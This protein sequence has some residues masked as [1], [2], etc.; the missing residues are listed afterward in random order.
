MK[1][2]EYKEIVRRISNGALRQRFPGL[3]KIAL[4]DVA[5]T[6]AVNI[7]ARLY[8]ANVDGVESPL[9]R[10]DE[11]TLSASELLTEKEVIK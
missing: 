1:S 11:P 10:T 5:R 8:G 7:H 2:S 3:N 9:W 4:A 6:I